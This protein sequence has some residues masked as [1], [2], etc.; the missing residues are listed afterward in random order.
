MAETPTVTLIEDGGAAAAEEEFFRCPEF[1]EAE[2][3]T[4]TLVLEGGDSRAAIPLIVREIPDS[5][6]LRDASSPYSY[7]GA[8]TNGPPIEPARLPLADSG[9]V[10]VFVRDRLG[11]PPGLAAGSDRSVVLVSAPE[12]PRKSRM[13]DRQQI[14]KNEA[15]GYGVERVPGPETSAEQRAEFLSVYTETM[16]HVDAGERYMFDAVYFDRLF[17]S[18]LTWLLCVRAPG[19]EMAAA[20]LGVRSDGFLHYYLSGTADAHRK[21]APSKNLIVATTDLGDEL[22]LPMNLGGG[23]KPGDG[24]EEFKRG[25]ANTELP[26]RTHELV[27]DAEAYARLAGK[28]EDTGFF[29][30]YRAPAG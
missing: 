4:H 28:R 8:R 23:V 18:E 3:T 10:S 25:F 12:L 5:G 14:R 24:L 17:S 19:G 15:A 1:L 7:P 16:R 2:G 9:L 13:S 11:E 30:L 27:C 6:G 22:G 29:P 21:G 26:F 20:A